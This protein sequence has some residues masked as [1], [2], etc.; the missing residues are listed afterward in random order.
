MPDQP[1]AAVLTDTAER[2]WRWVLDQVRTDEVGPWIPGRVTGTSADETPPAYRDGMHSGI[3]GLAHA[4]AEIRLHRPWTEEE[5]ELAEA[6]GATAARTRARPSPATNFFDGLVSDVGAFVALG[7]TGRPPPSTG[8]RTWPSRTGG[9]SRLL[10][11]P[12]CLPDAR[13]ND[14]TLGTASILLG[15]LWADRHGVAGARAVSREAPRTCC[16]PRRRTST[17]GLR[18]AVRADP[19]PHRRRR[20]RCPTGRTGRPASRARW[21]SPATELDRPDLVD[22]ARRGAEHLVRLGDRER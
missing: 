2:A 9:R 19:L 7:R 18:L 1:N 11:P 22:A 15:A 12:R 21:R 6:I 17:G 16:W 4:L 8:W 10:R 14:A 20:P 5:S 13:V 3:A